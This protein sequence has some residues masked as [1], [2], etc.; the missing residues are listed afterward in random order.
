MPEAG[1]QGL[2]ATGRDRLRPTETH[3]SSCCDLQRQKRARQ[4]E[5]QLAQRVQ[6]KGSCTRVR[7]G[8]FQYYMLYFLAYKSI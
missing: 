5:G 1:S 4:D 7:Y 6:A 2:R 8:A 3:T